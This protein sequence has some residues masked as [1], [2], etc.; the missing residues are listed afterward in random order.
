M[1]KSYQELTSGQKISLTHSIN[2]QTIRFMEHHQKDIS[3]Y[4][5]KQDVIN[6]LYFFWLR[7]CAESNYIWAKNMN[8]LMLTDSEIKFIKSKFEETLVEYVRKTPSV[9]YDRRLFRNI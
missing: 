7:T 3:N 2:A 8:A 6:D 4:R 9:H 5:S 1:K